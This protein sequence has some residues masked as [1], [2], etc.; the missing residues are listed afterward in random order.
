MYRREPRAIDRPI[1]GRS[2][3]RSGRGN[4]RRRGRDGNNGRGGPPSSNNDHV[5]TNSI[6]GC[7]GN[8]GRGGLPS[9]NN[10]HVT[11]NSIIYVTN[12]SGQQSNDNKR[13]DERR[14]SIGMSLLGTALFTQ[15][16][17]INETKDDNIDTSQQKLSLNEKQIHEAQQLNEPKNAMNAYLQN[18][19]PSNVI[20]PRPPQ[21]KLEEVM[22]EPINEIILESYFNIRKTFRYSHLFSSWKKRYVV[23]TTTKLIIYSSDKLVK[24]IRSINFSPHTEHFLIKSDELRN[25]NGMMI[26][27]N[28]SDEKEETIYM[29]TLGNKGGTL[30]SHP[31]L[32]HWNKKLKSILKPHGYEMLC[33]LNK[34][35]QDIQQTFQKWRSYIGGIKTNEFWDAINGTNDYDEEDANLIRTVLMLPPNG[36]QKEYEREAEL[37]LKLEPLHDIIKYTE[38]D[39]SDC[40]T[41]G[42][43]F[44]SKKEMIQDRILF[45]K[46]TMKN[47]MEDHMKIYNCS[48]ISILKSM[49]ETIQ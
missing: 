26:G 19:S 39:G 9:S 42:S 24:R 35:L 3:G 30:E 25:G 43:S 32:K 17:Q 38:K 1:R 22:I 5:T 27:I 14:A 28:N 29:T 16:D 34:Q 47:E 46:D 10:D 23:L 21:I 7:D 48:E 2:G 36:K 8:N 49:E 18:E 31:V 11:T 4:R 12:S 20:P 45:L 15:T 33:G 41:L 44:F 40:N 13:V 37:L 6:I